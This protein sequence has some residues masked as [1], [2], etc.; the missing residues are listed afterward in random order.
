MNV[1]LDTNILTRSA[2]QTHALH[3][4]AV[5]AVAELRRQGKAPCLVPQNIVEFWVVATK[6]V[7]ANGLGLSIAEAEDELLKIEQLFAVLPD[8]PNLID[9]WKELVVRYAVSGTKAYDVRLVA[10]MEIHGIPEILT[11]NSTDFTR[12]SGISVHSPQDIL[13]Q[14]TP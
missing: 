14:Q 5:D 7:A 4:V 2:Q 6:T 13:K 11:F 12:Y 3:P 10:A 1:L 8:P 9:K